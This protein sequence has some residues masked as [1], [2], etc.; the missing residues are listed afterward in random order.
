MT[1]VTTPH[2]QD[3]RL[4]SNTISA[5][6]CQGEFKHP[7]LIKNRRPGSERNRGRGPCSEQL[8]AAMFAVDSLAGRGSARAVMGDYKNRIR[9]GLIMRRS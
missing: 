5:T 9:P 4:V 7:R 8:Q 1:C 2:A 6:I 3:V